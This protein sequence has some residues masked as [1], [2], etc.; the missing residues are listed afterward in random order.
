MPLEK[1]ITFINHY[2]SLEKLRFNNH[3]QFNIKVDESINE[4]SIKIPPMLIQP[5]VENSIKHGISAK[6]EGNIN[7]HFWIDEKENNLLCSVMDNGI[8][9]KKSSE[10]KKQNEIGHQSIATDLI[11]ERIKLYN[12]KRKKDLYTMNIIDIYD[13]NNNPIGTKVEYTFPLN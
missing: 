3:F 12:Y 13:A 10:Q 9:R 11:A 7:I 6:N 2:L 5:V 1:E 8:G 4:Y